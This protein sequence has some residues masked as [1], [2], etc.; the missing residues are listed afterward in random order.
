MQN[1]FDN[2]YVIVD[3]N[4]F[5]PICFSNITVETIMDNSTIS[6][7]NQSWIYFCCPNCNKHSHVEVSN[8]LIQ[9]GLLDGAPGP[10]FVCCS[11]LHSSE[12]FVDVKPD[13]IVCEYMDKFYEFP[14]KN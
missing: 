3:N 14:A 6:W 10:N 8:N 4:L 12:L 2:K 9:T 7:T 13:K 1:I 11:Q 5:C